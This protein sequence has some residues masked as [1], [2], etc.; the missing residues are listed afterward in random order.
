MRHALE[1]TDPDCSALR[2]SGTGPSRRRGRK[3]GGLDPRR[4]TALIAAIIA[5]AIAVPLSFGSSHREA[6]LTSIAPT[7]DDT[8]LYA[9]TAADAPGA[10]TVVANWI[11]F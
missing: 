1:L 10:L 5:A 9:Y 2:I 3:Q 4:R 8:D 11:P 7:G 6:P